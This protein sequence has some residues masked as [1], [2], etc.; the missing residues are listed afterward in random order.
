MDQSS[1][2]KDPSYYATDLLFDGTHFDL[3]L[4]EGI[5]AEPIN[6]APLLEDWEELNERERLQLASEIKLDLAASVYIPDELV[7]CA[8]AD[9][10]EH[11]YFLFWAYPQNASQEIDEVVGS[12]NAWS[13][14]IYGPE[15]AW[16]IEGNTYDAD[17]GGWRE[18]ESLYVVD[19]VP[20]LAQDDLIPGLLLEEGG[21]FKLDLPF[22][23][24]SPELHI[25]DDDLLEK[26][27]SGEGKQLQALSGVRSQLQAELIDCGYEE[28]RDAGD[29]GVLHNYV[30]IYATDGDV[31][32]FVDELRADKD[33]SD[34]STV[35][36]IR[37]AEMSGSIY[38]P[39]TGLWVE[40]KNLY[41]YE[42]VAVST[43]A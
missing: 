5:G 12:W 20:V 43:A 18:V 41:L 40:G 34:G 8:D 10:T 15:I 35:E 6:A 22:G 33:E 38:Q 9:G 42:F 25:N 28:Y 17:K 32:E 3:D 19:I 30:V 39:S 23:I 37:L 13:D 31:Q 36:M 2:A 24:D 26:L 14:E 21:T 1:I 27:S 16:V 29:D 11:R 7:E 4:P